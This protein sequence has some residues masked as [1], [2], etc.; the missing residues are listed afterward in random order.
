MAT[1]TSAGSGDWSSGAT[2]V[3]GSVPVDNDTVVIAS[4]H[5]VVFDVDTS[6][7]AN[8]IAGLTITG[9][10]NVSATTSSY[11]KMKASAYIGGAGTFNVGTSGTPI[12][13]AVKFTLTGGSGWYVRGNDGL[14]MGVYGTEPTYT[15]AKLTDAESAGSTRLEI[16]TDLTGDL[17]AV[18]DS[19]NI[20]N[21]NKAKSVELRVI[22]SIS[23]TYIDITTGLGSTKLIDSFVVLITRNVNIVGVGANVLQNFQ[24]EKL[25]LDGGLFT[26]NGQRFAVSCTNMLVSG[27]VFSGN[28]YTLYAPTDAYVT[29]SIFVNNTSMFASTTNPTA[30]NVVCVG[31]DVCFDNSQRFVLANS[32]VAGQGGMIGSCREAIVSNCLIYGLFSAL[33]SSFSIKILNTTVN[34]VTN[35]FEQTSLYANNVVVNAT[36]ENIGYANLSKATYSESIDHDQVAGAFK[37]WTKGGVTTSV[38]TPVPTGKPRSWQIA[39]ENATSDG[40]FKRHFNV[41]AGKTV[42]FNLWLRKSASMTYLPKAWVHELDVEPIVSTT[43]VLHTFE[44]TNSVDTWETDS[45]EYTN[46]ANYDVAI[47]VTIAGMDATGYVYGYV[48]DVFAGG[49]IS[50]A[51]ILGGV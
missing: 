20:C 18:G 11:L 22:S 48:E 28:S 31:N 24:S 14:T 2:W 34:N 36:I 33:S 30:I 26:S 3:G 12:P 8:G 19:V 4:G 41:P 25:M 47:D 44:M 13:F 10:L 5:V 40:F 21:V 49:G 17:W 45:F 32:I 27:G 6:G 51:R 16:D 43:G 23:S 1:I 7:F 9:T 15:Y 42:T 38:D 39:L 46:S 37:A 50:R 29:E 35:G